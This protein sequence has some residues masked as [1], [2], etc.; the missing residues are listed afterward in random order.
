MTSALLL[1]TAVAV[2]APPPTD[3]LSFA[4]GRLTH[5]DGDGFRVC[6][7]DGGGPGLRMGVCSGDGGKHGR[8]ALLYRGFVVPPGTVAVRFRA[9]A[10][11]PR[12]VDPGAALDVLMETAE[13]RLVPKQRRG[14]DGWRTVDRVAPLRYGQAEEYVFNVEALQGR[15][16]RLILV[17]ED[18]RPGCFLVCSGFRLVPRD[19]AEYQDFS[20]HMLALVRDRGV[21]PPARYDSRHFIALSNADEVFTERSLYHCEIIYPVFFEHFRKKG[22]A[23]RPPTGKL[24]VAL[25]DRQ[26]GF[27]AYLGRPVRP[28]L[29]G[30]YDRQDN[31]LLAYDY[32]TN[33]A[34]TANREKGEA[35]IAR[36]PTELDRRRIFDDFSRRVRDFRDDVNTATVMHEVAHHLSFNGGLLNRQGDVP[37]WLCEGLACYCEPVRNGSWQGPGYPN[38]PRTDTLTSALPSGQLIPLRTLIEGDD[39]LFKE[40]NTER[41]LLGYAQSWALFRMLMEERPADLR[42]YLALI[43]DRRTPEHRFADFGEAFGNPEKFEVRY[44]DYMKQVVA[45]EGKVAR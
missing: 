2:A 12:G 40:S 8:K 3:N 15:W 31:R 32:G 20:R 39:W 28:T 5:W 29:T 41:R 38:G 7:A 1:L 17:D 4:S 23:V 36:I 26:S 9:A 35:T 30:L 10:V 27:E 33:G 22:F 21:K 42:R 11:R 16:V 34:F 6:P 13:R 37:A 14:A 25:F 44:R 24:M 43:A 45:R 18:A 19:E